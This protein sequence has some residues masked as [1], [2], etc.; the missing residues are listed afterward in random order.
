MV[1]FELLYNKAQVYDMVLPN[2]N[3]GVEVFK[4]CQHFKFSRKISS[5]NNN[6]IVTIKEQLRKIFGDLTFSVFNK[7]LPGG[8]FTQSGAIT[9]VKVETD[10][11]LT[12]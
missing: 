4:Q 3:L 2:G 9:Q 6:E 12:L 11:D 1:E 5:S 10:E 7:N 8:V